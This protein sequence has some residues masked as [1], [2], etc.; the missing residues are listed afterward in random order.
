VRPAAYPPPTLLF[1]RLFILEGFLRL[2]PPAVG[3]GVADAIVIVIVAR[4]DFDDDHV[5]CRG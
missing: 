2:G 3:V 1:R 4:A 5:T